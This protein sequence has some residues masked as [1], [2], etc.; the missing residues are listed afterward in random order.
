MLTSVAS[1][2]LDRCCLQGSKT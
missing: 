2:V 1:H